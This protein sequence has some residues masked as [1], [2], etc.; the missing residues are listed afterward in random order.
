MVIL[1]IPAVGQEAI[2][3]A[4][5]RRLR[6]CLVSENWDGFDDEDQDYFKYLLQSDRLRDAY[7]IV[8]NDRQVHLTMMVDFTSTGPLSLITLH[9][10]VL[11][12]AQY[13]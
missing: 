4:Q 3:L 9:I 13:V 8:M 1:G 11:N 6:H 12:L 2:P 7:V 5:N 10:T